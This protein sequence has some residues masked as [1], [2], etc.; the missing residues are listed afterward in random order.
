MYT[1][2]GVLRSFRLHSAK[3]DS[4]GLLRFCV[5]FLHTQIVLHTCTTRPLVDRKGEID[6]KHYLPVLVTQNPAATI[7]SR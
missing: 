5:L 2:T 6:Q 4:S 3:I 7:P 1:Q